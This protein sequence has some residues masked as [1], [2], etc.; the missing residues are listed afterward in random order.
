VKAYHA[1]L[2]AKTKRDLYAEFQKP[3]SVIRILL[4]SDAMAHGADVSNITLC[5]LSVA[6]IECRTA[7]G[8]DQSLSSSSRR[9]ALARISG[10]QQLHAYIHKDP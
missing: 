3:G 8:G 7:Y 9:P 4:T 2:S 1:N 5:D 10:N 6:P